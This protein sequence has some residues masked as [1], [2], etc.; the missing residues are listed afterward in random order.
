[1]VVNPNSFDAGVFICQLIIGFV[2]LSLYKKIGAL[3]LAVSVICFLVGGL[4]I[5]TGYD[6]SSYSQTVTSSGTINQ[7]S[8]FIGNGSFPE[9]GTGQLWM[10]WGL[11]VLALVVGIIFLAETVN[12]NLIKG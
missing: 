5:L 1:M 8:Y 3:L 7:T 10:G 4:L 6:I 12:G 2:C 9:N 11:T